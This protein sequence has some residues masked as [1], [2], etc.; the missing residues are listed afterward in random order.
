M[1]SHSNDSTSMLA[2]RQALD[3]AKSSPEPDI[4]FNKHQFKV[5]LT[6][7]R[8]RKAKE[9]MTWE[10]I[11]SFC[12]LSLQI[13]EDLP[14]MHLGESVS[15]HTSLSVLC[16]FASLFFKHTH[17]Y[18]HMRAHFLSLSFSLYG[19]Y[20]NKPSDPLPPHLDFCPFFW[21]CSFK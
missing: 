16:C 10:E 18:T 8:K 9:D 19:L 7:S 2:N 12:F 15:V 13:I 4:Q 6:R 14:N 11:G 20:P 5:L 21:G 17:A 1:L 3:A